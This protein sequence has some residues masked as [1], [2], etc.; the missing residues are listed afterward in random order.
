MEF[1]LVPIVAVTSSDVLRYAAAF[2]FVLVALGIVYA[3]I[4][5]AKTLDRVDVV[6]AD[7][8]REAMPL[9]QKAAVTLDNVN[10]NLTNVDEIT[11]DVADITDKID[12][13][14]N[15]IEGAVSKPARK[16]AAFSAGLQTAMS[17]FMRRDKEAESGPAEPPAEEPTVVWTTETP[18]GAGGDAMAGAAESDVNVEP[19]TPASG[20]GMTWSEPTPIVAPV[21]EGPAA[22]TGRTR[23]E[24]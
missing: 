10:A 4:K 3:C 17:T 15:V 22:G 13:M 6:M 8:D 24:A 11:K 2:F 1:Q 19:E 21:D 12:S 16:A 20:A 9:L 23:T 18:G 14:A 7:V 5:V